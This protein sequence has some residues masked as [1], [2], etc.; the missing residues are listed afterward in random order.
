LAKGLH[1]GAELREG[2]NP[3]L[4]LVKQHEDLLVLS[5]LVVIQM[6]HLLNTAS[7]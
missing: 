1:D 7:D 4:V 2:E 5:H 3:V 6:P